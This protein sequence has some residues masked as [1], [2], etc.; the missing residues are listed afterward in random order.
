MD[1]A[2]EASGDPRADNGTALHR[3]DL[4]QGAARS[5]HL[6]LDE[7]D[8][9]PDA[10]RVTGQD[11]AAVSAYDNAVGLTR[12]CT[13]ASGD[14][15]IGPGSTNASG[16]QEPVQVFVSGSE[17]A[18]RVHEAGLDGDPIFERD[19]TF[20]GLSGLPLGTLP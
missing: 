1:G 20:A 13:D 8:S 19:L 2:E 6:V 9:P 16:C 11:F 17:N 5:E 12:V 10:L 18:A 3:P 14:Y 7:E 15:P 4:Q